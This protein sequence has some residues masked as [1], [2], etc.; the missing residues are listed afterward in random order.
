[1]TGWIVE[2]LVTL[3]ALMLLVLA[4]RG[5]VARMFGA[6]WSYALWAIPALRLILPP[7]VLVRPEIPLPAAFAAQPPA[8]AGAAFAE[9]SA[10]LGWGPLLLAVWGGGAI[11]FLT[12][13]WLGYRAFSKRLRTGARVARPARYEGIKAM[14]SPAADGPLA[15]GFLERLIVLPGDF[16]RRY[17]PDQ[18]RLAIRHELTHHRRRDTWWNLVALVVL[19]LNWFNPVAW[20]AFRAFRT[21]QEL[22]CDAAVAVGATPQE[23]HDYA[24][25]MVKSA[26]RPGLIAACPMGEAAMLKRRLRMMGAHRASPGRSAGGAAA[27]AAMALTG[28]AVGAPAFTQIKAVPAAPLPVLA[29]RAATVPDAPPAPVA[30]ALAGTLAAPAPKAAPAPAPVAVRERPAPAAVSAAPP[31]PEPAEAPHAP[32]QLAADTQASLERLLPR[33]A[34]LTERAAARPQVVIVGGQDGP[35]V[36][37]L[38][39]KDGKPRFLVVRRTS[40]LSERHALTRELRRAVDAHSRAAARTLRLERRVSAGAGGNFADA[41]VFT[42]EQGETKR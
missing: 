32:V 23:R 35:R 28:F 26:S 34:A 40:E 27:L 36:T 31:A 33:L 2:T 21:D 18:R 13:Q 7:V 29:A 16:S 22:A 10:P 4:L 39:D 11:L 1:M 42:I 19:A 3:T 15:L 17:S 8:T 38:A 25:A 41:Q 5:P 24:L 37:R 30:R 14:I 12:L 6:G 9:A 20:I